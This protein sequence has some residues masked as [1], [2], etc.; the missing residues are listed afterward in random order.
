MRLSTCLKKPFANDSNQLNKDFYYELLYILG[1]EE[2]K[3]GSKKLIDRPE[4]KARIEGS[5]IEN[6]INKLQTGGRWK[7]VSNL[8]SY[9]DDEEKQIF[10][11]AL[12][13][14]ISWLNRVLFLKLLEGQLIRYQATA[15]A[16]N[17]KVAFLN[18]E[19]IADYT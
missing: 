5:I 4:A 8:S 15:K 9:G 1:L 11:I 6:T 14:S 2:K 19:S 16:K 3:D 12:E 10:S 7:N 18:T 13:L 17:E